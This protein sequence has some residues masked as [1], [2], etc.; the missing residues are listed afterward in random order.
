MT[1]QFIDRVI[2]EGMVDT[3]DYR[4]TVKEVM[5]KNGLVNQIQRL[6]IDYLGTTAA[7]DGWETVATVS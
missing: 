4:Y 5:G 7:I 2:N 3:K 6:P 1:K